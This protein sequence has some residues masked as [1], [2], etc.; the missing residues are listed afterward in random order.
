MNRKQAWPRLSY[1]EHRETIETLHLWTQIVGKV[2]LACTP[3]LNHSWHVP[4]YV[5]ASGLGTGLVPYAVRSFQIDF[6]FIRHRLLVS[7]T[8]GERQEVALR[9]RTVADF[10]ADVRRALA[11]LRF[12]V[13]IHE[14]PNEI[15]DAIPFRRD[16]THASYDADYAHALW[17]A[18]VQIDRVFNRFRT[19]WLGKSSPVH[20]FWGSFDM[21]VTR[22]SGS[23]APLHPG[24][25]PNL[26]DEVTREAYSHECSS[27]GFWPGGGGVDEPMFYSYAYP[28]P[29]GFADQA[30][31]PEAARFHTD[32]GEFVLPYEAVRSADDP[33]ATLLAF[34]NGT[35]EAAATLGGWDRKALECEIGEPRRPRAVR[36]A[37]D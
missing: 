28:V 14:T 23:R 7:T 31:E 3:W 26:S 37:G 32:L 17:L 33:D 9:P 11:A 29:D 10:Y 36:P 22:F 24:G 15:P 16:T 25:F 19:G 18:L 6:D 34:L 27:A 20:F 5:N 2:R 35:Y 12:D 4:L 21:A 1:P 30:V 13:S 8:A